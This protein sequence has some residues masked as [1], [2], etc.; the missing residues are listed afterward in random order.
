MESRNSENPP[1]FLSGTFVR[2]PATA[3]ESDAR[4]A[5]TS[6][7]GASHHRAA[8]MNPW[9]PRMEVQ[10][11]LAVVARPP[12]PKV[13]RP[14]DGRLSGREG[15]SRWAPDHYGPGRP[16]HRHRPGDACAD[17]GAEQVR[18]V[19]TVSAG[20]GEGSAHARRRHA[21]SPELA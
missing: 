4:L 12:G 10:H 21:L 20:M 2:S 18:R 8:R 19:G 17:G 3:P 11:S 13:A 6:S 7:A 1:Q 5:M 9:S 14:K 16:G 15:L